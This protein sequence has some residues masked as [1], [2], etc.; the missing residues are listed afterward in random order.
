MQNDIYERITNLIVERLQAGI[1]PWKQP[2]SSDT[3]PRN[4]ITS[5]P[6][7]GINFWLLL[8]TGHDSP[9]YLS[10]QQVKTLGGSI[11]KGEKSL[12]VVFWKL[13]DTEEKDGTI[14]KTPF[15]K[16]YNVFNLSQTEGI[17]PT[18][19]PAL[20]LP[21]PNF[22][23]IA[24]AEELVEQWKD[25]PQ[26]KF[27]QSQA[28][29]SLT[30]DFIGMPNPQSFFNAP[31]YYSVLFHEATHST[32][33]IKR[34]GRHA[35]MRDLNFGSHSYSQEE[36]IAEM[37]AAY[38]CGICGIE[39]QTIPNSTAYIQSWIRTFKNDPKILVIAAAQAQKAVGY[40]LNDHSS[41]DPIP[42]EKELILEPLE[43]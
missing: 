41:G 33:N 28:Y 37:G 35:K 22:D 30:Q 29:Y 14:K 12:P 2:W 7:H 15:L 20:E 36:L 16:Y 6:Y 24:K 13:L 31:E 19:L 11:K 32:G 40:I 4:M 9:F 21:N 1:I 3:Y 39:Q 17:D 10:F 18:K 5:R 27:N 23:P 38:L 25:C 8:S 42:E 43:A 26:I 34:L